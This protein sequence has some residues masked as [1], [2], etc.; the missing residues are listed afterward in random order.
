M[1]LSLNFVKDYIDIDENV[2]IKDL[3]EA[4]TKAGNEYDEAEKLI[5]EKH[6]VMRKIISLEKKLYIDKS[7]I[8]RDPGPD[9]YLYIL[10]QELNNIE[11]VLDIG[12][13]NNT[14]K[15]NIYI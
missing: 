9:V 12:K 5:N 13:N 3:A 6:K 7:D 2:D 4:M 11:L 8:T 10:N 1:K 14:N 15:S